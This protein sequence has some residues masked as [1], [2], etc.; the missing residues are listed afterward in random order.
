MARIFQDSSRNAENFG[1]A[2]QH[3]AAKSE[4]GGGSACEQVVGEVSFSLN[5]FKSENYLLRVLSCLC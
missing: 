2:T 5:A 3:W 1:W 4:M